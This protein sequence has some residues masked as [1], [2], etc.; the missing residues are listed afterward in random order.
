MELGS[1]LAG[2]LDMRKGHRGKD[3]GSGSLQ[4]RCVQVVVTLETGE[5]IQPEYQSTASSRSG[6]S[7]IRKVPPGFLLLCP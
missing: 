5:M 3:D 6:Q 2:T 4:P 7:A 1:T